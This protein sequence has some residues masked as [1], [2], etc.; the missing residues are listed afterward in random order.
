LKT[1]AKMDLKKYDKLR[2][3]INTKDFE[4][5]NR[6]LDKW[7]FRFS[8]VGNASSIFFAYFLVFP[9]LLK[10]ISVNF[11]TGNWA[12]ALAFALTLIFLVIFEITKRYFIRN[13]SHDF[14]V[15][16]KKVGFK[17]MSWF[18]ISITIVAL[19]FYLS[20]TGSKKL[21]TTSSVNDVVALEKTTS[22]IDSLKAI[23]D[24][25]KSVYL[26]DNR[27]L[28]TINNDLREKLVSTP[29]N[30]RTVRNEYQVSIDKNSEVITENETKIDIIDTEFEARIKELNLG[31][32]ETKTRNQDEDT[33]NILL[34]IVIVVFNELIIIGGLYFREYFEYNLFIINQEKYEK[35][36]RKKDRYRALISFIYRDGKLTSGDRVMPGSELKEIVKDKTSIPNSSKFVDEFLRDMDT[37]GIFVTVGKRRNI[38]MTYVEAL[39][40]IENYDDTY[41]VLENMK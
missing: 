40:T 27:S 32:D 9:S 17:L 33:K 24:E 25:R 14:V 21:A 38:R 19:S 39:D 5:N 20:I 35:I 31:L 8:F 41:R 7:L 16:A 28:R 36:Y 3:K 2:Q 11:L 37:I 22:E 15:N 1:K 13:F 6:G 30:Y 26:N 34:F 10:A 4:G 23:F 18:M 29:L 12:I